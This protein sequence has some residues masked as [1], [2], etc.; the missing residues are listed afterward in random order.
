LMV[1]I[2]FAIGLCGFVV[3]HKLLGDPGITFTKA[4]RTNALSDDEAQ[5]ERYKMNRVRRA[6]QGH[7]TEIFPRLNN[8]FTTKE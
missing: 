6:L 5:G 1:P 4:A 2:F 7:P 3:G 8:M